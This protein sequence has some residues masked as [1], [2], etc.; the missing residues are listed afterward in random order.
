VHQGVAAIDQP[1]Q[2]GA[3]PPDQTLES[4]VENACQAPNMAE[5]DVVQ[6]TGFDPHHR[7]ARDS[8]GGG[9]VDLAQPTAEPEGPERGAD[10]LILHGAQSGVPPLSGAYRV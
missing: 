3:A 10:A 1:V 5:R 4:S 2:V 8:G 6:S 7:A 9:D